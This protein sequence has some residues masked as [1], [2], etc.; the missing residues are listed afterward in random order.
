METHTTAKFKSKV[1]VNDVGREEIHDVYT[2]KGVRESG[3]YKHGHLVIDPERRVNRYHRLPGNPLSGD[4]GSHDWNAATN[5]V[6]AEA[7]VFGPRQLAW[8]HHG[9][10][11]RVAASSL[12]STFYF[13][14]VRPLVNGRPSETEVVLMYGPTPIL[15]PGT[16]GAVHYDLA[17]DA[18]KTASALPAGVCRQTGC[19]GI[20]LDRLAR[21][22]TRYLIRL[23]LQDE[24]KAM[25]LDQ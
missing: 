7:L 6:E 20:A 13:S 23:D 5:P 18:V 15:L 1:V 4:N 10:R 17:N 21:D 9:R 3:D 25:K 19:D 8:Y 14:A 12:G 16:M 22:H 2:E 24:G 11:I